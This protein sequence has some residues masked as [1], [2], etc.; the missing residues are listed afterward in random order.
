[1]DGLAV[2]SL[3]TMDERERKKHIELRRQRERWKQLKKHNNYVYISIYA[4]RNTNER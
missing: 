3:C 1:M 4:A 2:H